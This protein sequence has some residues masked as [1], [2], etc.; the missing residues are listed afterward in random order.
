MRIFFFKYNDVKFHF[1][2]Y[3]YRAILRVWKFGVVFDYNSITNKLKK[4][5]L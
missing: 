4:W 1:H 5:Q 3:T 2:A